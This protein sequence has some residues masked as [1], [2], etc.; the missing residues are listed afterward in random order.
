M[1]V[2]QRSNYR[3]YSK[4]SLTTAAHYVMKFNTPIMKAAR[5][6]GVPAS[7]LK[8]HIKNK[9]TGTLESVVLPTTPSLISD[10][11]ERKLIEYIK[12]M[13]KCGF[14]LTKKEIIDFG[15]ELASASQEIEGS[16]T[17]SDSW[18]I[19]FVKRWPPLGLINREGRSPTPQDIKK[20][21]TEL[22]KVFNKHKFF[23]RPE[24]VY[25]LDEVDIALEYN[26]LKLVP[27]KRFDKSKT[28][29]PTLTSVIGCSNALGTTLPP[30]YI[31][32]SDEI[33]SDV[34]AQSPPGT[35]ATFA[36]SGPKDCSIVRDYFQNH[37]MRFAQSGRNTQNRF[38]LVF[39]D[40]RKTNLNVSDLE[41]AKRWHIL[42]YPL[43][44]PV[45]AENYYEMEAMDG[46]FKNYTAD[47]EEERGQFVSNKGYMAVSMPDICGILGKAYRRSLTYEHIVSCFENWGIYPLNP[48]NYV[49]RLEASFQ[50]KLQDLQ[51]VPNYE[52]NLWLLSDFGCTQA[53]N[54]AIESSFNSI[55]TNESNS[56]NSYYR[57]EN[58]TA[59]SN[60]SRQTSG[61]NI[62]LCNPGYNEE[63]TSFN[64]SYHQILN[65]VAIKTEPQM[66]LNYGN[67]SM[68]S[69]SQIQN[70][71]SQSQYGLERSV[72]SASE[73]S[74]NTQ[75]F[76]V[77][78]EVTEMRIVQNGTSFSSH[79]S[80]TSNYGATENT[81]NSSSSQLCQD[82]ASSSL[83]SAVSELS[84]QITGNTGHVK[85]KCESSSSSRREKER[86]IE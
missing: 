12:M 56:S 34:I 51:A 45:K 62:S 53:V 43:P 49:T 68:D 65:G 46:M 19:D 52:A 42:L 38:V 77:V 4:D 72:S 57:N 74:Q 73:E 22:N 70:G 10:R 21:F 58:N 67:I 59:S 8:D 29:Q 13:E 1:S 2:F 28:T 35:Q 84:S 80:C 20:Y 61:T 41:W 82:N 44:H 78:P 66:D 25:V 83:S 30:Y 47:V 23:E 17:L 16:I 39:Y 48:R 3:Q 7:T 79:E 86:V 31:L 63:D 37:F 81:D 18:Y 27:G 11:D 9:M 54:N 85:S 33:V 75:N 15:S 60:Y 5:M 6:F 50:V 36:N 14:V 55:Y 71:Y 64:A 76:H 69:R 24:L 32:Q 26:P 40:S